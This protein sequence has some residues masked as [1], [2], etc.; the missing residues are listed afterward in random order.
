[1]PI[2]TDPSDFESIRQRTLRLA[3]Q[4]AHFGIWE[5]DLATNIIT[6]SAGAASM[7]GLPPEFC[8]VDVS[9]VEARIHPDDR[10]EVLTK[11]V[12]SI[13]QREVYETEFRV[14]EPDGVVRWRRS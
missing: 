1:M 5:L 14:I 11:Q 4:A 8:R 13:R 10:A 2:L 12:Q 3:E 6:L 9:V 7:S